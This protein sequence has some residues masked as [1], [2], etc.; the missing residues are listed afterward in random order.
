M[1]GPDVALSH[2]MRPLVRSL[3]RA[4]TTW[5]LLLGLGVPLGLAAGSGCGPGGGGGGIGEPVGQFSSGLT[6][7][8]AADTNSCDTTQVAGLT[9]QLIEQVN[10]IA[11]DSLVSF[12][13][14]GVV[15]SGSE[16]TAVLEPPAAAA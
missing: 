7:S 9:A 11:P 16:V 1:P 3:A 5:V 13:G 4:G 12:E 15:L 2:L 14:P 8:E 6:V 10:C